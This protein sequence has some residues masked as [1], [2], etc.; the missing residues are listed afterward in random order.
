MIGAKSRWNGYFWNSSTRLVP[1]SVYNTSSQ[2]CVCGQLHCAIA[3]RATVAF[4]HN[5]TF[6]NQN[7]V[8]LTTIEF[9]FRSPFSV[10]FHTHLILFSLLNVAIVL[11]PRMPQHRNK[12]QISFVLRLFEC[13]VL[14]LCFRNLM[15]IFIWHFF[16]RIFVG[17]S[18]END[19]C[20]SAVT[21]T[22][23]VKRI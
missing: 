17:S 18:T 1:S 16:R 7:N 13:E 5:Y 9:A 10:H 12:W 20:R 2:N 22:N 8:R 14:F 4:T 15:R 23:D 19:N 21:E 6:K 11:L 3:S